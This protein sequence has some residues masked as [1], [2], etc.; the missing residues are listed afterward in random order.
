MKEI[1]TAN[2]WV[3]SGNCRSCA[4]NAEVWINTNAAGYQFKV[5]L[6]SRN[7]YFILHN[8]RKIHTGNVNDIQAKIT[9]I[10][11]PISA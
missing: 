8:G 6:G 10:S 3:Y 7:D 1:L 5:F 11:Q 2:G 4:G 9:E